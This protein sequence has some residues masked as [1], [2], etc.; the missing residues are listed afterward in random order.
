VTLAVVRIL[1]VGLM[2]SG[3]SSVGRAIAARTGWPCLDNDEELQRRTGSTAAE[4]L[5][6]QGLPGLRAA[7]SEVLTAVL[8]TPP[9]L[10]AGVAAGTVLDPV[11]RARLRAGGHVVWLRPPVAALAE[12][13]FGAPHRPWLDEAPLEVL[14]AMASE[15][16]PLFAAVAHQVVDTVA[17]SPDEVAEQV[18]AAVRRGAGPAA[19]PDR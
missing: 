3:K 5:A 12:R 11:D 2:G 1:L 8:A 15:R 7:E 9:P 13:A 17:L 6:L 4:L 14:R 16:D 19:R 18:V 10:V